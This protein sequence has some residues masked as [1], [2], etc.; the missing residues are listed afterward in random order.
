MISTRAMPAPSPAR[1]VALHHRRST[2]SLNDFAGAL[3]VP[4]A[5]HLRRIRRNGPGRSP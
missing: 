5:G 4:P 1:R 3:G 2:P